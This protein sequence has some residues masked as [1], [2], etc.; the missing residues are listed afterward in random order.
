MR[1][2]LNLVYFFTV[3]WQLFL[4]CFNIADEQYMNSITNAIL[5]AVIM[6]HGVTQ[7]IHSYD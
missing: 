3:V 7:P 4:F 1:I 2:I 6:I 5:I